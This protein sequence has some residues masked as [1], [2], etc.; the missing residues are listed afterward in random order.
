[1][2]LAALSILFLGALYAMTGLSFIL[3]PFM[4]MIGGFL[5]PG[6]PVANMYF[7]LFSYS[8]S[9]QYVPPP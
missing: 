1:V 6:K 2:L 4:Q 9:P 5:L 8:A 7:V 3:Q